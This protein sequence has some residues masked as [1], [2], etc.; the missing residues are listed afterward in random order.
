MR[1]QTTSLRDA[2]TINKR[3]TKNNLVHLIY[4]PK[5]AIGKLSLRDAKVTTTLTSLLLHE[6]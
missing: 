3:E 4:D 6:V 1:V 2:F 5:C